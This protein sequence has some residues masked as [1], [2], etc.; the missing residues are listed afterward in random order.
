MKAIHTI[1]FTPRYRHGF[2]LEILLKKIPQRTGQS[3]HQ[4]SLIRNVSSL[5]VPS[6]TA[7][8]HPGDCGSVLI[9][10]SFISKL[11]RCTPSP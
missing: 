6:L 7:I 4:S 1:V 10:H 9:A 11:H 8:P 3:I 5:T 2:F